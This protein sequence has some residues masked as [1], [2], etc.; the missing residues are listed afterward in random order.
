M[1]AFLQNISTMNVWDPILYPHVVSTI[2][3]SDPFEGLH[4]FFWGGCI[5]S[6]FTIEF[7][8]CVKKKNTSSRIQGTIAWSMW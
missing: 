5:W 7:S 8:I 6:I 4:W 1:Y 3:A 2:F